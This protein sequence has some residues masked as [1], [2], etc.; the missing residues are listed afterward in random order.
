MQDMKDLLCKIYDN[1]S[2]CRRLRTSQRT[3][4]TE[5]KV[6]NPYLTQLLA[7]TPYNFSNYTTEFDMLSGYLLRYLYFN[8]SYDKDYKPFE[9]RTPELNIE[10]EDLK[11]S[12]KAL[13][14]LFVSHN[15]RFEPDN[16]ALKIYQEWQKSMETVVL[17]NKSEVER[18]GFTRLSV[19]ALKLAMIYE[20]GDNNFSKTADPTFDALTE[21]YPA[22]YDKT[23]IMNIS[24]FYME[25]AI[26]HITEYFFPSFVDVVNVVN[27]QQSHNIQDKIISF[28][29]KYNG[30]VSRTQLFRYLKR[31]TADIDPEIDALKESMMIK[32][33][34]ATESNG[35]TSKIYAI[36]N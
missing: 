8:P 5:F 25:L 7:T 21:A 15:I 18:S 26:K 27:M 3:N 24:P 22:N 9:K 2:Y 35:K 13:K 23:V 4:K 32:E 1:K 14:N 34:S 6:D 28:M 30:K 19:Y 11:T 33:L 36:L 16:E 20:M 31:K 10:Y 12:F 29:K 17:K